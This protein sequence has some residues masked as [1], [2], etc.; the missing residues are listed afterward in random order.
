M[1]PA[2]NK[3]KHLSSINHTTKTIH[4]HRIY[5]KQIEIHSTIQHFVVF[6]LIYALFKFERFSENICS[7]CLRMLGKTS[8]INTSVSCSLIACSENFA[9]I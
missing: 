1:V 6:L 9:V 3:A 5:A 4:H 8:C 7:A 2:G